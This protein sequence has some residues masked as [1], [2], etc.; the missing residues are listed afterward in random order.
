MNCL[1]MMPNGKYN[2]ETM[3]RMEVWPG[4]RGTGGQEAGGQGDRRLV[5]RETGARGHGDMRLVDRGTGDWWT[6][7]QEARRQGDRRQVDRWT[8]S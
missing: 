3:P 7:G 1:L 6:A 2:R 8:G 4:A 5:N